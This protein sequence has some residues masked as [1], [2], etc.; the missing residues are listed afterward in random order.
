MG[1]SYPNTAG[2]LS[3]ITIVVPGI[4]LI[5]IYV[6]LQLATANVSAN[7]Y[8]GSIPGMAAGVSTGFSMPYASGGFQAADVQY[9]TNVASTYTHAISI[10]SVTS[11]I[12]TNGITCQYSWL[13]IA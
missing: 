2:T 5:R 6:Q 9:I 1:A 3:T 13:R 4:Y 11:S 8:L 12:A 7:A 10:N